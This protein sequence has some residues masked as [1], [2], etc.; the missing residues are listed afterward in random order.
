M[1]SRSLGPAI[2]DLL[3]RGG[4]GYQLFICGTLHRALQRLVYNLISQSSYGTIF[5][6]GCVILLVNKSGDVGIASGGD[7]GFADI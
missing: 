6:S 3:F 1:L 7:D 2:V 4:F 5:L